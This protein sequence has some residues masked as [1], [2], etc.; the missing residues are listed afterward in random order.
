[1]GS[2]SN[3]F[4]Y[5]RLWDDCRPLVLWETYATQPNQLY[6]GKICLLNSCCSFLRVHEYSKGSSML[7]VE[8]DSKVVHNG[9]SEYS[10]MFDASCPP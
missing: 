6:T 5:I 7:T 2:V 9:S 3:A 1:M 8:Y 10:G 4:N